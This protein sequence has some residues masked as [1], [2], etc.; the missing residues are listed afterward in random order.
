MVSWRNASSSAQLNAATDGK[1]NDFVL[2]F[3]FFYFK[4]ITNSK[5]F[6]VSNAQTNTIL[7]WFSAQILFLWC[8]CNGARPVLRQLLLHIW[9]NGLQDIQA[10]GMMQKNC[11]LKQP[12]LFMCNIKRCEIVMGNVSCHL[13]CRFLLLCGGLNSSDHVGGALCYGA[14]RRYSVKRSAGSASGPQLDS[15]LNNPRWKDLFFFFFLCCTWGCL[16]PLSP[17]FPLPTCTLTS[18]FLHLSVSVGSTN[19]FSVSALFVDVLEKTVEGEAAALTKAKTLY[20]SCTNERK[21]AGIKC[22]SRT[23]VAFYLKRLF[24]LNT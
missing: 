24:F 6:P 7:F 13:S 14:N 2:N 1:H 4:K 15:I 16:L 20:K 5:I 12:Q 23:L 18:H 21:S 22:W 19:L 9:S 8:V 3:L 10:F 17:S 11:H